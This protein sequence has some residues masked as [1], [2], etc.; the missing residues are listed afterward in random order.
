VRSWLATR[1]DVDA[2]RIGI[3]GASK[4]AEFALLAA[5][6]YDWI[7]AVVAIVPSDVVWE[8]WGKAGVTTAS[9]SFDGKPLPFVPYANMDV[10]FAQLKRGEPA[11]MRM[12]H[13]TGRAAN[14]DRIAAA[15][16]PIESYRGA[17][18]LVAGEKDKLWPSADMA[19]NIVSS[20]KAAGLATDALI[21]DDAGHALA[22]PGTSPAAPLAD[23]GG[24]PASVAHARA[25]AWQK[26]FATF[27]R[28]LKR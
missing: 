12:P 21:F 20:R 28:A 3:W 13:D 15:R 2:S 5:S 18:L 14:P 16:I 6:K 26:T 23:I 9:F 10:F 17:L 24:T 8:G 11:E 27:E 25:L 7:K 4:G 22:G 1:P 19:R